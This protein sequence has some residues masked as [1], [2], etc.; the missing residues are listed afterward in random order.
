MLWLQ[1]PR[2]R[3]VLSIFWLVLR[4]FDCV[5][6]LQIWSNL[7][8]SSIFIVIFKRNIERVYLKIMIHSTQIRKIKIMHKLYQINHIFDIFTQIN[9]M[10]TF[11]V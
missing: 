3:Q 7:S 8:R 2:Q 6:T 11:L 4:N 10:Y 1:K 5:P 9:Q